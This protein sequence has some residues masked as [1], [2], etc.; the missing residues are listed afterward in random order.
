MNRGYVKLF[1]KLKDSK[2]MSDPAA[3]SVWIWCLM[4]ASYKVRHVSVDT[5]RG[6]TLVTLQPGEFI[7]GRNVTA[8]RLGLK[9]STFE[10]RLKMLQNEEML[11]IQPGTH[12]SKITVVNWHTYQ[13]VEQPSEQPPEQPSEQATNNQRT[14]IEHKQEVEVGLEVEP[15]KESKKN[16]SP[17]PTSEA[18]SL[19]DLLADLITARKSDYRSVQADKRPK[20]VESW[21]RTFD[22]M[23]RLD[24]REWNTAEKVLRWSQSDTFWS[25]NILSADKFRSQF[26]KLQM[27]MEKKPTTPRRTEMFSGFGE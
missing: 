1:R 7:C 14:G 20:T 12:F 27:Q 15:K 19:A 10:R 26:D 17:P 23:H 21:A 3:V 8:K 18:T 9:P 24:N 25:A 13:C 5:G 16:P 4:K 6:K 2:I 22:K 11:N